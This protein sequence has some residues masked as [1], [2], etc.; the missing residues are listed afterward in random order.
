MHIDVIKAGVI[1]GT[2][3]I[4]STGVILGTGVILSGAKNLYFTDEGSL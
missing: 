3:V 1:L 2:G 4:L